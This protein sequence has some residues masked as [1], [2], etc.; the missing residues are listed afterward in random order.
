M[1][2]SLRELYEEGAPDDEVALVLR[3]ADS[4]VVPDGVRVVARFGDIATCR[5]RREDIL[6]LHAMEVVRSVKAPRLVLPGWDDDADAGGVRPG[7][8]DEFGVDGAPAWGPD[9]Q[10]RPDN[11]AA[12][13]AGV[14]LAHID[15]GLDVTHPDLRHPDGRTRVVALWDQG[16]AYDP[17]RPNALGVRP[18]PSQRGH[19]SRLAEHRSVRSARLRSAPTSPRGGSHG[20]HTLGISG[21]NGRAG[22][23]SGLAPRALL[24]FVDLSTRR[25]LGSTDLGQSAALLESLEFL[26][27]LAREPGLADG[28]AP[29]DAAPLRLVINASLGCQ[30]GQHDG[31]TLTERAMDAFLLEAPGRAIVQSAGNYF[32]HGIHASDVLRPG[33]RHALRVEIG[34]GAATHHE[35]DLWYP[36]TDRF[37]CAV[38]PPD[39]SPAIDAQPGHRA[40]ITIA[41]RVVGRLYH[42]I[43][44]PNNGDNEITL[45]LDATAPAGT[46]RLNLE[47]VDVVDGRFHAWI[48]RGPSGPFARARFADGDDRPGTTTGTIS[49]GWRTISETWDPHHSAAR[50]MAPF[51]SQGPTRDG[52]DKPDLVAPGVRILS[53]RSRGLHDGVGP[54]LATGAGLLTCMSGTS[55]AAPHVAGT[56]A[57]V[58]EAAGRALHINETRRLLLANVVPAPAALD[59]I[60]RARLGCGYLDVRAAIAAAARLAQAADAVPGESARVETAPLVV[61]TGVLESGGRLRIDRARVAVARH[62]RRGAHDIRDV[63]AGHHRGRPARDAGPSARNHARG[64]RSR[65]AP[66]SSS[67]AFHERHRRSQRVRIASTPRPSRRPCSPPPSCRPPGPARRRSTRPPGWPR[68]RSRAMSADA[69][70]SPRSR[71][72]SSCRSTAARRRWPCPWAAAIRRSPSRCRSEVRRHPHQ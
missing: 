14:L 22:G 42:R 65:A 28:T 58:F 46:W 25:D 48:E 7:A 63:D 26:A 20:T 38:V 47:G 3:L 9:D 59:P 37:G 70:A 24:A 53:A 13:G 60:T 16:A 5:V 11:L 10:R 62:R 36:G 12:T 56:L 23:P 2:P 33:A 40:K 27:R 72:R 17:A 31:R 8:P 6:R 4:L 71:S 41:G 57:C 44:D 32:S 66:C 68:R 18:H 45:F 52:R 67:G 51:S 49:N 1:D 19:R 39:G 55:M 61:A 54:A 69:G 21:G 35:V 43:G 30:A 29:G 64:R 50:A 34:T 15:W